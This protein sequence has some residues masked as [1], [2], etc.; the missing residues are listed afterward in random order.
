[1][2]T[3]L[4]LDENINRLVLLF[5]AFYSVENKNQ[6]RARQNISSKCSYKGGF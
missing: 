5:N 1:M 3:M 6:S 4:C 2:R